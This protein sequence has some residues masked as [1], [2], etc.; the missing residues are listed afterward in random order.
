MHAPHSEQ[1]A[2]VLKELIGDATETIAFVNGHACIALL[3][4]GSQVTS[5]SKSFYH[6]RIK[7]STG[8]IGCSDKCVVGA[9]GNEVPFLGYVTV[10]VSFPKG[11]MGAEGLLK[12][13]ALVVPNNNYN[14]RVPVI[15]GTNLVKQ[16]R[17]VCRR[18]AR[19]RFLQTANILSTW[20]RV[21]QFIHSQ[22]KF[23]RRLDS[24]EN[25]IKSTS[26][27]PTTIAPHE[28]KVLMRLVDTS[29]GSS[30][31]VILETSTGTN[32]IPGLVATVSE[33]GNNFD[34]LFDLDDT[35]LSAEQKERT[36][37]ILKRMSH[38]FARA[39]NDLG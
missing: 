4:T 23:V 21:Y 26:H 16:C 8:W 9:G 28:R 33:D 20:R 2:N 5:I 19:W 25:Q 12:T 32:H 29:P 1:V 24:P 3:D 10:N 18:V 31:Q 22:E 13:L 34:N 11:E 30:T 17:D 38:V 39:Q 27:H 36:L 37:G 35:P 7:F 6:R 15:I 14:Q